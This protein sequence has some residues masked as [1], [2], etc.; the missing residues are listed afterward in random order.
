MDIGQST[1]AYEAWAR[2]H[3]G[4][5]TVARDLRR[6]RK[7]MR[8][9]AFAFLRATYWRW[10]ERILAWC[11][12]LADAPPVLSVGDVHL[13][14]F[15]TWRD[16]E[17]RLVFGV[18]DVDEAA[19]MPWPLDLVRLAA[20][21][22]LAGR[23]GDRLLEARCAELLAG[24]AAGLARPAPQV[25]DHAPRR[26]GGRSLP[27]LLAVTEAYRR[28]FWTKFSAA[29]L[30]A[31]AR[32]DAIDD[33]V[34]PPRLHAALLASL[35]PGAVARGCHPRSAGAG[36]LGR[37]RWVL[38]AEWRGAPLL[39]EAK[40][41]LPSAWTR[42][43]HAGALSSRCAELAFGPH[44][45]PDPWLA[46][47]DDVVVRRLSPNNRKLDSDD[48][49][50]LLLDGAV[51][52]AMAADLAALHAG[53]AAAL[54]AVRGDLARRERGWLAGAAR[55]AAAATAEEFAAFAR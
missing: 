7:K 33:L 5:E 44:R 48:D 24:Y 45:A 16:A 15:G 35:P 40:A 38:L 52:R 28:E 3:L 29:E 47:R 8:D 43:N 17:G 11:P 23:D 12:E 32:K 13:E 51:L 34:I 54:P 30:A 10:A 21:L 9:G 26:D 27:E 25:L 49:R 36:S 31:A 46:I 39:R 18:N 1:A 6:K 20:S 37:P 55:R 41:I 50:A 42:Q 4:D 22:A 2:A 14:N 19:S 53:D